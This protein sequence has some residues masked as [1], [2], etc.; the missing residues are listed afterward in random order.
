MIEVVAIVPDLPGVDE[1]FPDRYDPREF[2]TRLGLGVAALGHRALRGRFIE[3]E[4]QLSAETQSRRI[5]L[6]QR[7]T[8]RETPS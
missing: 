5:Q 8:Q 4:E 6:C 3:I 2:E 7:Q 1:L